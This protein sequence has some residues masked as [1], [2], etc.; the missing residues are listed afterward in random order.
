[1]YDAGLVVNEGISD[2]DMITSFQKID[3]T[4]AKLIDLLE[5][6]GR[7][8]N[9][10]LAHQLDISE[11]SVATRLKSLVDSH[12]I[13][14]SAI[15]D[16]HAA[17]YDLILTIGVRTNSR[18]TRKV[19]EELAKIDEVISIVLM[20]GEYNIEMMLISP[21]H[22]VLHNFVTKKLSKLKGIESLSVGLALQV[23]KF[24][25]NWAPHFSYTDLKI[26]DKSL[27]EF[28]NV[29]KNIIKELWND[30]RTSFQS[31]ANKLS[32]SEATVRMR[33]R[34]MCANKNIKITAMTNM[35]FHQAGLVAFLSIN[36]FD[37][38]QERILDRLQKFVFVRFLAVVLGRCDILAVVLVKDPLE[39]S[40]II[41]KINNVPGI[42]NITVAQ[43]LESIKY[44]PRWTRIV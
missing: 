18:Y 9:R 39:L 26:F 33:V 15:V 38:V 1:M 8:S 20:A 11:K 2:N 17:G 29:N 14:I 35:S 7:T 12:K 31:I 28:D 37:N 23:E 19:A 34:K 27:S 44:D 41:E 13:K 4:D 10:E 24:Q 42:N 43:G 25:T 21:D 40:R 6:N 3:E 5:Q 36:I 30:A 32:L 16:I 22:L